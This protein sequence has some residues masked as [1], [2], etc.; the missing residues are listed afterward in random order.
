MIPQVDAITAVKAPPQLQQV[1]VK[2][3]LIYASRDNQ[4]RLMVMQRDIA[5][6]LNKPV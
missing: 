2:P 1:T 4:M 5:K 6:S 3:R